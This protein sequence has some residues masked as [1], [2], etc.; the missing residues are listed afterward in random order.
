[1]FEFE[2]GYFPEVESGYQ[3]SVTCFHQHSVLKTQ[4]CPSMV[5][6]PAD[7][8]FG[9]ALSCWWTHSWLPTVSSCTL[10]AT[11][12]AGRHLGDNL[13]RPCFQFFWVHTRTEVARYVDS[14]IFF[15][16]P[17]YCIFIVAIYLIFLSTVHK[18]FNFFTAPPKF[19]IYFFLS[20]Y[21]KPLS[22]SFFFYTVN[23]GTQTTGSGGEGCSIPG[24][25]LLTH[26][27]ASAV[28]SA[29]GVRLPTHCR[30]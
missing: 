14:L 13:L 22:S 25:P 3:T 7:V 17:S 5:L 19:S 21:L 11:M 15:R 29:H 30:F 4:W 23:I 12:N 18:G 26:R 28:H 8:D 6:F 27:G 10:T 9:Y 16:K 24:Q 1:M 2:Y 20:G